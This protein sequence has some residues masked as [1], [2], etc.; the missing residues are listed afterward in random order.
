MP[1]WFAPPLS[2]LGG[3]LAKLVDLGA[4]YLAGRKVQE[5]GDLRETTAAQA[6]QAAAAAAAPKSKEELLDR[7]EEHRL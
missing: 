1:A 4:A 5:A 6:R 7:L 2:A 3:F